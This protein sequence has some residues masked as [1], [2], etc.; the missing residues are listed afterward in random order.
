MGNPVR[1]RGLGD[2]YKAQDVPAAMRTLHGSFGMV[3]EGA[4]A[5][6]VAALLAGKVPAEGRAVAVLSGRNVDSDT[7]VRTLAA[8]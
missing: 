8:A 1:Y 6:A 2:A 5:A 4:G 3:A 7:L